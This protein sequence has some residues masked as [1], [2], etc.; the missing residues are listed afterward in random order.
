MTRTWV[1]R[2]KIVLIGMVMLSGLKPLLASALGPESHLRFVTKSGDVINP[3]CVV[4]AYQKASGVAVGPDGKGGSLSDDRYLLK[5]FVYSSSENFYARVELNKSIIIPIPPFFSV[6]NGY[7]TSQIVFLKPGYL[8]LWMHG[9]DSA[10]N[11]TLT[12]EADSSKQMEKIVEAILQ[13]QAGAKLLADYFMVTSSKI[14]GQ[15]IIDYTAADDEVLRN[16][17]VDR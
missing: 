14:K 8:P 13:R 5:P 17:L 7:I 16:C 9:S 15:V 3:V 6:G 2:F 11:Q 1:R 4:A 10:V 12:L